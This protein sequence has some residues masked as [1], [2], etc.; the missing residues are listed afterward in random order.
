MT[1]APPAGGLGETLAVFD[2]TGT[3]LTTPEV[4]A[5]LDIGR[6]STYDR[7]TRLVDR[8]DLATKKVGAGG[9]V[10][11]RPPAAAG[12]SLGTEATPHDTAAV[13]GEHDPDRSGWL[14]SVLDQA[15]AGVIVLDED[16]TVHWLNERAARFFDLDRSAALGRDK[17]RLVTEAIAPILAEPNRFTD[18][19]LGVYEDDTATERFDCHVTPGDGRDERWLEHVSRPIERGPLAGGRIETYHDV[20]SFSDRAMLLE[21]QRD[22]LQSGLDEVFERITD[23]FYALDGDYRLTY[24][25]GRAR[26][27]LELDDSA[28]GTDIRDVVEPTDA[29]AFALDDAFEQSDPVFLEDYYEPVDAWFENVIYPSETG[30]SVYFQEITERKQRE[31]ELERYVGIVEAVGD[32]IYELDIEGRFTFVNDAFVEQSGYSESELLGEHVS[33][34][35]DDD[36]I[37]RAQEFFVEL[38]ASGADRTVSFEYDV[39]TKDG[40]RIPAENRFTLLSDDEGR[41]RGSAGVLHDISER[42][43][44]ERQLA[45]T[46]RRYRAIVDNFPNGT[47]VLF[48]EDLRYLTAGGETFGELAL[49]ATE[50]EGGTVE[51]RLPERLAAALKPHYVAAFDGKSNEFEVEFGGEVRTFRTMP[52][53]DED[54]DVFAGMAMSQDV[55]ERKERERTLRRQR[56]QLAAVNSLNEIVHEITDAVIEQSTREEI[57]ETVCERLAASESYVHAWVGEVDVTTQDVRLRTESGIDGYI[58]GVTITVDPEDEYGQ[59]PTGRAFRTGEIQVTRDILADETQ[60]PWWGHAEKQG[61]RSSAT[62]PVVYEGTVYAVLNVYARRTNAFGDTERR[63][64]GRL[65]EVIGHAIA[66]TE[67]KQALMSDEVVELEFRVPNIYG[68]GTHVDAVPGTIAFEHAVAIADDDYIEYGTATPEAIEGVEALVEARE[69]W[70]DVTVRDR[71]SSVGFEIRR[72]T[73]PLASKVASMG[74]SVES[75]VVEEGVGWLTVHLSPTT[76]VRQVIEVVRETFPTAEMVRR[77]QFTRDAE[78]PNHR[79]ET[80]FADLTDRQRSTLEAAYY[81]GYFRWP[82]DATAEEIAATLGIAPPTFHQHLRKAQ[83]KTFERIMPAVLPGV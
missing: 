67:R 10:W 47:V 21:R 16:F 9:R 69:D 23:G 62:I 52:V 64:L 68:M 41:V 48:D 71:G 20:T 27:L 54:G 11:W 70:L 45:E 57:E 43:D 19:A 39:V 3:P 81:S 13:G 4:A 55:T 38:F 58:E 80:L 65:G 8:G 66:A 33:I 17:R 42:R 79:P 76:D 1:D 83:Q 56:E 74:G 15:A 37:E 24:V 25:N 2:T 28:I 59:G 40:E 30:V 36:A 29:F 35:M 75:A 31:N 61:I 44:R 7:L 12:N 50:L 73:S 32:P 49:S 77:Q 18:A 78:V 53:Y 34:G 22:D 14:G 6:R 51:E 60:A 82:R 26:S 63:G 5:R 72:S 46:E